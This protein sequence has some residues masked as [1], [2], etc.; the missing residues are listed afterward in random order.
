MAQTNPYETTAAEIYE[1]IE[2][3][4]TIRTIRVKPEKPIPFKTGQFIELTIPNIGEGRLHHR[5]RIISR[6]RWILRS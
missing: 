2:E 1:I 3:S 4:P 6:M 5:L